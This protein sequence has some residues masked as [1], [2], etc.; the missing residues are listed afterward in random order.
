MKS[1]VFV[2]VVFDQDVKCGPLRSNSRQ[3]VV[4]TVDGQEAK[5]MSSRSSVEDKIR[6]HPSNSLPPTEEMSWQLSGVQHSMFQLES[7]KAKPQSRDV[8][9][10]DAKNARTTRVAKSRAQD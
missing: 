8:F 10:G 2:V 4:E 6:G 9:W 7:F 5:G 3:G 1:V